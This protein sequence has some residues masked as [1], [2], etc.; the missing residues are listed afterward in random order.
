MS[1]PPGNAVIIGPGMVADTHARAIAGSDHVHLHGVLGRDPAHARAFAEAH[2]T[3]LFP[4]LEAIIADPDAGFVI[5]ATPPDTRADLIAPLARA[6]LPVLC[7]K[8]LARNTTEAR[9]LVETCESAGVPLGVVLQYQMRPLA[10][11]LLRRIR[12]G[13]LGRIASVEMRLPWWRDQ[14]YYDTPGRGTHSR[15]GGG[16]LITQAIHSIDLMLRLCGPVTRVQALTATTVLHD[17][18][19]EDFAAAG[20]IFASGAVGSLM[21]STTHFPGAAEEIIL[22]G[23]RASATL[24][25][26]QLIFRPHAGTEQVIGA[27]QGTGGGADP[28]AFSPDWHRA[29][30]EDFAAALAEHRPPAITGRSALAAHALIDAITV[31]ARKGRAVDLPP[32]EAD[33]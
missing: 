32:E 8:P 5:L 28:M 16:V 21:A 31:S 23:T 15:D 3:R 11:D 14:S 27:P 29:V 26:A 4:D 1:R 30:I 2:A 19:A 17:L 25:A 13:D 12:A 22:N 9:A 18:E 20:L 24:S 7:E 6:G 10:R 33:V